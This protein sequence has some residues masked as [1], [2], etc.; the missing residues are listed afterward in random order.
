MSEV[1]RRAPHTPFIMLTARGNEKT[2]VSVMK[3]GAWDYL[4]KPFDNDELVLTVERAL[5]RSR[6][7]ASDRRR[8]AQDAM[9]GLV[10]G[11]SDSFR[12]LL[13]AAQRVADRDITV[14]IQGET[15]TG[16][17]MIAS[18]IHAHS[19]RSRQPL[20]RFNCA[21]I[22][23]S[24]A[25]AE[26][27]GYEKG[28]FTGAARRHDG[29]F[30]RADRGTLV[31][32]EVGDLPPSV[33]SGLL[34][35][36]QQGEVQ[37]LGARDLVT[38][39]VR[40]IACTNASL[41]ERVRAGQFREDLYYRLNVVDLSVP[42]LRQRVDDIPRLTRHFQLKYAERFGLSDA[43]LPER[44]VEELCRRPWPGNVR[45][46]ENEVARL[47]ALSDD[48]QLQGEAELSSPPHGSESEGSLRDRVAAF[49]RAAIEQALSDS[50]GNQSEAARRLRTTR[51]TVIDKMKRLG[52]FNERGVR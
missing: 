42:P 37:P 39:D 20:I 49:E 10:I 2:A 41:A 28:A 19:S 29:F 16:K 43:P 21:A 9:P 46:L 6:L 36:L 52:I 14:L 22:T 17:E 44:L 15:G 7:L 24:L 27:F 3:Q 45:Q 18:L 38:V 23:E 26:L 51:T 30:R 31:L 35:A 33:Q 12:Q 25:Q 1:K 13:A 48:G 4:V 11:E 34:R 50:G 40:V 5:E 47:L 8:T 32:D